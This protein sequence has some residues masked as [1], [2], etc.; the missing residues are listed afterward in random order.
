[1]V[2]RSYYAAFHAAQAVLYARGENPS[3]HGHVRRQFG[4]RVVL[5]GDASREEATP[6]HPLRLSTRGGLRRWRAGR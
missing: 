3:S 4:Q 1:M 5:N 2:N 6:E